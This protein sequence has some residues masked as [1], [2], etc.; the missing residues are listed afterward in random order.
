VIEINGRF[1]Q[2]REQP[3]PK[4]GSVALAAF[5]AVA[6]IYGGLK[7]G[8]SNLNSYQASIQEYQRILKKES[9]LSSNARKAVVLWFTRNYVEVE[10]STVRRNLLT[11]KGYTPYCGAD[12]CSR[13]MPRTSFNGSQF[14]CSCGWVSDFPKHFMYHYFQKWGNSNG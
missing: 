9:K 13:G 8:A 4:G 5:M 12:K 1:Y 2:E 10:L 7:F 11:E 6:S 3:T 14:E